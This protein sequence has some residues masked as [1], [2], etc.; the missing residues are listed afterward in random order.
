MSYNIQHFFEKNHIN[1][2]NIKYITHKERRTFLYLFDDQQFSTL[3]PVRDILSYLPEDDYLNI[4]K[5]IVL[6]K[7]Q[8]IHISDTGVYTMTDGQTF[9]GRKRTL[10]YHK[11]M[12]KALN[13]SSIEQSDSYQ[14]PLGLLEKCTLMD[15]MPVAFCVI[16]LVFDADGHGIDF[17]FRYCNQAM[18]LVE[19]V[20]VDQMINRSFYEVFPSGDK[21]W[22]VTYADVALNGTKRILEDFSPEI[23]K[24]LTIHCYQ[25]CDGHCACILVPK[26]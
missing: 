15:E 25:P 1:S 21:K 23:N 14:A 17:V 18:E 13:L 3:I 8:I 5:G 11:D 12:R 7:N 10:R 24:T 9:Q 20:P 22:L 6:K 19:G 26:E 4:S 2:E 16:E